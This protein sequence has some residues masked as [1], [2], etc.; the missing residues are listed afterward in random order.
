M[1]TVVVVVVAPSFEPDAQIVHRD[2]LVRVQAFIAQPPVERLDQS[3][4]RGL[5][6][7]REVELDAAAVRPVVESLGG[8]LGAVVD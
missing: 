8:E 4:V 3:V 1:G 2:E 5:A 7:A 6:G